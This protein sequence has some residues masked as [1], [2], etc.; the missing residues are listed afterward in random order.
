MAK[1]ILE[2]QREDPEEFRLYQQERLIV[3]V[4]ELICK[5]LNQRGMRRIDLARALGK[6]RG[7]VSQYLDGEKNLTLRTVADIFTALGL[8][9]RVSAD[10]LTPEQKADG[11]VDIGLPPHWGKQSAW[12][13]SIWADSGFCPSELAA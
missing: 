11:V 2:Q 5:V 8:R 13:D 10:P 6:T 12:K 7:R 1:T 9:M 3:A 4:T